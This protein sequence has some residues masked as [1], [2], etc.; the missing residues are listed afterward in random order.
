MI[1]QCGDDVDHEKHRRKA[2]RVMAISEDRNVRRVCQE[3]V[4]Y[5]DT[6]GS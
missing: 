2:K 5:L 4:D 3:I 6:I 1:V